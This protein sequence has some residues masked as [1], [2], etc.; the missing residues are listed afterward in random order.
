MTKTISK[1]GN[2]QGI[3]FDT[4]LMDLTRLKVGDEVNVTVHE[5]GSIVLTPVRPT[6]ATKTAAAAAKRLI[7]KNSSLFKRLA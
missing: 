7:K 4:A 1:V 2:S 6:I 5:G 3:I